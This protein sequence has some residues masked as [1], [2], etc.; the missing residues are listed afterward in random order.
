MAGG[1]Y[2]SFT[3]T[4]LG[5]TTGSFIAVKFTAALTTNTGAAVTLDRKYSFGLAGT[6]DKLWAQ[7]DTGLANGTALTFGGY[8]T[9]PNNVTAGTLYRGDLNAPVTNSSSTLTGAF[10]NG[11][12]AVADTTYTLTLTRT[13]T[14]A[15]LDLSQTKVNNNWSAVTRTLTTAQA[16]AITLDKFFIGFNG[17]TTAGNYI[18][19]VTNLSVQVYL[20]PVKRVSLSVLTSPN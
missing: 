10:T 1:L 14:G 4:T 17:G 20:P 16:N 2:N 11:V 6:D 5:A 8:V 19:T 15:N 7:L 13:A 9:A 3:P 12:G 18:F